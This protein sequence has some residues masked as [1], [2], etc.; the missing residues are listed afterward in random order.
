[1][2]AKGVVDTHALPL[3][4]NSIPTIVT[5]Q[6]MPWF[7]IIIQIENSYRV[8]IPDK[9]DWNSATIHSKR[10]WDCVS[11][12]SEMNT[13]KKINIG[14]SSQTLGREGI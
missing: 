10:V 13:Q 9:K 4:S 5:C 1:M 12:V 11:A 14:L 6:V 3:R 8:I 2:V 7:K